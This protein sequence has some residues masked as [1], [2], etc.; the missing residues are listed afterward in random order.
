M[1]GK[2]NQRNKVQRFYCPYCERQLRRLGS[3]KHF[4]FYLSASEIQEN[5]RMPRRSAVFLANKGEYIDTNSWIEEFFCDEHG[6]LWM[7]VTRKSDGK[8]V[9]ILATSKDWQQTTRTIQPDAPN[10]S[11]GE[12]TYSMSR[13]NGKK[14]YDKL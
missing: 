10:P 6:K 11:V 5:V 9:M 7:K 12:F 1:P 4:L 3:P 14:Y 13:Q 2:R 8:A